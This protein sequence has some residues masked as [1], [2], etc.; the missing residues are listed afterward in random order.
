MGPKKTPKQKLEKINEK[1]DSEE[2]DSVTENY[3]S[4]D[5]AQPGSKAK[6]QAKTI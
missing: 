2:S 6:L 3:T 4:S 5:T 1:I